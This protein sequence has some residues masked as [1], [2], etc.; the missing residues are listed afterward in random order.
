M[1]HVGEA[2]KLPSYLQDILKRY[3]NIFDDITK[4]LPPSIEFKHMIELE[5]RSKLIMVTPYRYPKVYKDEIEND[6]GA[7]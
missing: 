1:S 2:R 7:T 6:Q 3:L 5:A 4:G